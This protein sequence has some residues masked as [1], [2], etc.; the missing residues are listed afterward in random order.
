MEKKGTK[1]IVEIFLEHT[2]LFLGLFLLLDLIVAGILFWFFAQR[3]TEMEIEAP[4][5]LVLN[6]ALLNDF[7]SQYSQR[8]IK[9]QEI[10]SKYYPDCFRSIY[11]P[12]AE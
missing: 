5:P 1:R 6:Q 11:I 7:S 9:F 3:A 2:T 10:Q 4:P 8:E 12:P